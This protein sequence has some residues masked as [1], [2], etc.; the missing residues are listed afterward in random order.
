M[1]WIAR[2]GAVAAIVGIVGLAVTGPALADTGNFGQQVRM[3]AHMMLPYNLN[4]DGSISM[5]MPD[6]TS[7]SF[8]TFGAMVAYM[9][10]HQMCS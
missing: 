7:M 1:S 6:A 4:S 9:R 8:R 5:T 10:S 2:L 3:C